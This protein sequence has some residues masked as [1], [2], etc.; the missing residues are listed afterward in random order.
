MFG[1]LIQTFLPLGRYLNNLVQF[2]LLN[3]HYTICINGEFED[4]ELFPGSCIIIIW[5]SLSC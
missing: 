5:Y 4:T 1:E 2:V 3:E